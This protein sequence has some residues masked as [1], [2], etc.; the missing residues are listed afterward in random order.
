MSKITKA[1]R[2]I[3]KTWIAD[4]TKYD[5]ATVQ[6]TADGYVTAMLDADKTFNGPH[7]IRLLAGNVESMLAAAAAKAGR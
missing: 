6:I 1:Q 4:E 3:I 5:A 7:T 2:A